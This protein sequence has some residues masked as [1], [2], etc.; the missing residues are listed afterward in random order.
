MKPIS[1]WTQKESLYKLNGKH[2]RKTNRIRKYVMDLKLSGRVALVTGGSKG[3]GRSI[4]LSLAQEGV[5][6]GMCARGKEDLEK[7]AQE[8]GSFGRQCLPVQADLNVPQECSRFI[9][10]AADHFGRADILVCCANVLSERGGTFTT[11]TDEDWVSHMNRKFFGYVRCAREVLPYM[12]E[13]KWGRIII[14]SGMATRLVRLIGM[15]NGP[16]CAAL[17]NFGKQLAAQVIGD[18]IRVN[19]IHPNLTRTQLVMDFLQKSANARGMTLDEIEKETASKLPLG[20]LQEPEDIAHLA[21]FLCSDLADAIT[22]QSLAVDAG[23]DMS[24]HY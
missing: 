5:D 20:R 24:V 14:I 9:K 2:L 12:Q 3:I 1:S 13:N 10:V 19:T 18:G 23:A 11:I 21:T 6:I 17:T 22:G 4:A 15:D 8:I 16:V 7:A